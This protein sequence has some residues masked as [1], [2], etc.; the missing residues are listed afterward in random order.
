MAFLK[1]RKKLCIIFNGNNSPFTMVTQNTK[2]LSELMKNFA[3]KVKAARKSDS[4]MR[5]EYIK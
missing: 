5:K 4:Y 2:T 1:F 3:N